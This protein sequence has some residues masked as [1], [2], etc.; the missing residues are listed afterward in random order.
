MVESVNANVSPTLHSILCNDFT[1]DDES[2]HPSREN[3]VPNEGWI[4]ILLGLL[5]TLRPVKLTFA[6]PCFARL[7][8][9]KLHSR[10]LKR[11]KTHGGQRCPIDPFSDRIYPI[12]SFQY[13]FSCQFSNSCDRSTGNFWSQFTFAIQVFCIRHLKKIMTGVNQP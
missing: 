7:R 2:R 8:K 9:H 12:R 1:T 4:L 11:H 5:L 6:H 10:V 3:E 13:S